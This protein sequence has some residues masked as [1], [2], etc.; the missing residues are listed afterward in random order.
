MGL[1]IVFLSTILFIAIYL[2]CHSLF[3]SFLIDRFRF[4]VFMPSGA[5]VFLA[6]VFESRGIIGV[7]LGT[8]LISYFFLSVHT[9]EISIAN[10]FFTGFGLY[11]ARKISTCALVLD[12]N[13][14]AITINQIAYVIVI[15]TSI[16][17]LTTQTFNYV[18]YPNNDF[19]WGFSENL[20]SNLLGA[21][22]VLLLIRISVRIYLFL[23]NKI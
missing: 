6:L 12:V 20:I 7:A 2:I 11:F 15:F 1:N 21:F 4:S 13:L 18:L 16:N 22:L 3:D 17:S 23:F 14:R 10:A 8:L 19:F 9:L 5:M